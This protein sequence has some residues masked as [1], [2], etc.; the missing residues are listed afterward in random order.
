VEIRNLR[1]SNLCCL[2]TQR[3][4]AR[5]DDETWCAGDPLVGR[6]RPTDQAAEARRR[7]THQ[8]TPAA[9]TATDRI[10]KAIQPQGVSLLV[11]SAFLDATAAPAAAAAPG[12]SPLVVVCVVVVVVVVTGGGAVV[13]AVAVETTVAVCTLVV[14]TTAVVVAITVVVGTRVVVAVVVVGEDVVV[15]G[16]VVA[17][18][19]SELVVRFVRDEIAVETAP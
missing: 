8:T 9:I 6:S 2:P 16:S 1:V 15:S 7:R 4:G 12:L 5:I 10:P 11:V 18:V 19:V 14:V 17:V 3:R 13:V